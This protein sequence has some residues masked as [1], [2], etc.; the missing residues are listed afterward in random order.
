MEKKAGMK[1]E[2]HIEKRLM[3]KYNRN[4][5][6]MSD[7]NKNRILSIFLIVFIS[8]LSYLFYPV[9]LGY[10][11]RLILAIPVLT[12]LLAIYAY[13]HGFKRLIT[14][15]IFILFILASIIILSITWYLYVNL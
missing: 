2:N 12:I 10:S 8:F 15:I 13:I 7:Q 4:L 1:T 6:K 11:Y 9:N 3:D 14:R 5:N